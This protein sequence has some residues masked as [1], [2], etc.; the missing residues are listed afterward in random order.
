[1]F[2]TGFCLGEI[3]VQSLHR[4]LKLCM[5]IE[6]SNRL[7][8][9]RAE[10]RTLPFQEHPL[11]GSE[12]ARICGWTSAGAGNSFRAFGGRGAQGTAGLRLGVLGASS[13]AR[14]LPG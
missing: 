4:S 9:P 10:G 8:N 3:W 5:R 1:M 7:T 14:G 11:G 6:G 12:K 13:R 2:L